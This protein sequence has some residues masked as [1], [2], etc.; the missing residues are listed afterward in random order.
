MATLKLTEQNFTETI[1]A[2]DM[3]IVDF[4]AQ[5]CPPCRNFAPVFESVSEKYPDIVFAK[6]NTEEEQGL[7]SHF[8]IRSIP[9]LMIFR[10]QIII[11]NQAGSLPAHHLE[12]VIQKALALDMNLVREEIAKQPREQ[13]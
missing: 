12:D 9:T 7:A 13:V 5:W 2:N 3:V 1:E 6:L 8:Q 10:G 4:W 11:F